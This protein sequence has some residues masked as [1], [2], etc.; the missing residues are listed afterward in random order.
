MSDVRVVRP[1]K[2]FLIHFAIHVVLI[3]LYFL[4]GG[5]AWNRLDPSVAG[6]PFSVFMWWVLLPLL[7]IVNMILYVRGHWAQDKLVSSEVR[8]GV[9]AQAASAA[10]EELAPD[11][12]AG[13]RTDEEGH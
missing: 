12:E 2:R 13:S 9:T 7:I 1:G 3:L 11:E 5:L 10:A 8:R 6:L 4:P